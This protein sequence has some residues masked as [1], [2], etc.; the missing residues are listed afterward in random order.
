MYQLKPKQLIALVL[1]TILWILLVQW[2]QEIPFSQYWILLADPENFVQ[3]VYRRT[4]YGITGTGLLAL[5]I[6]YFNAFRSEIH[7]GG[8]T[9]RYGLLWWLLL[10]GQLAISGGIFVF[11]NEGSGYGSPQA[12]APICAMLVMDVA[13]FFWIPTAMATPGPLKRVPWGSMFFDRLTG[14]K[15]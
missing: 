3:V 1:C 14:G 7:E 11:F 13:I 6:W 5:L 2:L 15:P 9:Q 12:Y 10:L 8:D 4:A